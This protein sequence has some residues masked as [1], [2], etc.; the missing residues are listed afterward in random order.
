MHRG[1]AGPPHTDEAVV[2]ETPS[3]TPL[4]SVA[5]VQPP[6]PPNPAPSHDGSDTAKAPQKVLTG[7][8]HRV[9]S[10]TYE[11]EKGLLAGNLEMP[12]AIERL[13]RSPS[14]AIRGN[15][16]SVE[17]FSIVAPFCTVIETDRP[18]FRWTPLSGATSYEVSIYDPDLNL[19]RTSG[20]ITANSWL[21]PVRLNRGA[22]YTWMV[23]ALKDAKEVVAPALPARAEFQVVEVA[24]RTKLARSLN[25][26][27]SHAARGVLY[28]Q[29]GLLDKAVAEFRAHLSLHPGDE[30]AKKLLSTLKSWRG[31]NN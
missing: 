9:G 18:T 30:N 5:E 22:V 16:G 20:L 4:P 12:P 1:S 14:E 17:S 2:V 13:D 21:I 6:A 25:D 29:A 10:Q 23:T 3:P 15:R 26:V 7:G 27:V 31:D 19:V 24:E 28:A 11:I 8:P